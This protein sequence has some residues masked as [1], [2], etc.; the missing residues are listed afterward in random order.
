DTVRGILDGH[1]VLTRSLAEQ[2]HYPA[3]DILTSVSR[4]MPH[5]TTIP[6]RAAADSLRRLAATFRSAEDLINIGAYTDGTNADIDRAKALMPQIRSFLIQTAD[7]HCRWDDTIAHLHRLA[8]QVDS[9]TPPPPHRQVG[10]TR[11][12]LARQDT[13]SRTSR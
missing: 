12:T 9:H 8:D 5:I 13:L 10:A 7:E 2:S 4:L 6:H 1:I 11:P 3:I